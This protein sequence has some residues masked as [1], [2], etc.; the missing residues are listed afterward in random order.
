MT[1]GASRSMCSS[2]SRGGSGGILL[3]WRGM[4]VTAILHW[5]PG[6]GP[7]WPALISLLYFVVLALQTFLGYQRLLAYHVPLGT[8][9]IAAAILLLVWVWRPVPRHH[10]IG[11]HLPAPVPA[12]AGRR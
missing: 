10:D 9:L 1:R 4:L 2:L 3:N 5:R 7:V 6:R 12:E 8:A 11:E